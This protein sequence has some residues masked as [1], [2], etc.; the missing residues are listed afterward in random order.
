MKDFLKL[1]KAFKQLKILLKME[2]SNRETLYGSSQWMK[3]ADMKVLLNPKTNQGLALGEWKLSEQE[4]CSHLLLSAPTMGGKSS[5]YVIP[6]LL[7]CTGSAIVTDPSGEIYK[8]TSGYLAS[9]GFEIKVIQPDNLAESL[10][11]NPLFYYRKPQELRQLADT[12]TENA[13]SGANDLFWKSRAR[14][15]IYLCLLALSNIP[16][17]QFNH[18]SNVLA[19]INGLSS[20]KKIAGD[21]M[22][23]FL[24]ILEY[25]RFK[26]F[27]NQD[28]TVVSDALST[29]AASLDMFEDENVQLLTSSD[30]MQLGTFRQKPTVYY[31]NILE[32]KVKYYSIVCNL[33]YSLFF[34]YCL[35]HPDGLIT[36]FLLDEFANLGKIR[37]FTTRITTLRK[38]KCS[39]SIILQ[40]ISQLETIY[41]RHEAKTIVSGGASNRLFFA[42]QDV[43]MGKYLEK[44]LGSYTTFD[45]D[46]GDKDPEARPIAKLLMSSTDIRTMNRNDAILI[47]GNKLPVKLTMLPFDRDERL[48]PLAKQPPHIYKPYG[49]NFDPQTQ[50]KVA[51][52][53]FTQDGLKGMMLTNKEKKELRAENLSK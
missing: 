15:I 5:R 43:D 49:E 33:I 29:A 4:S 19:L 8:A 12:L 39:I 1:R 42:G 34:D 22:K 31:L 13:T 47:S 18:L 52:L 27:I 28:D 25:D 44:V 17:Q 36:Y 16:E 46:L 6:A 23:K 3:E 30:N 50:E 9:K 37:D 2:R 38:R 11:F 45:N 24:P 14:S 51:Y 32:S 53:V 40:D 41:G 35:E 48:A 26:S 20:N 21:F 7:Q 10:R